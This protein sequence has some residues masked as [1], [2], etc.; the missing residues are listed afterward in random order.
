MGLTDESHCKT[1]AELGQE[2]KVIGV[3]NLPDFAKNGG[4]QAKLL[5][6]P[7]LFSADDTGVFSVERLEELRVE[8]LFLDSETHFERGRSWFVSKKKV[9]RRENGTFDGGLFSGMVRRLR[10]CD[11]AQERLS[12]LRRR[13]KEPVKLG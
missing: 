2:S 6:G 9:K 10:W 1:E 11:C 12:K 7:C 8:L 3:G 13:G 5:K 4:G